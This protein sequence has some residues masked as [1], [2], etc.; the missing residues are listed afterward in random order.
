MPEVFLG[1]VLIALLFG[2]AFYGFIKFLQKLANPKTQ[3]ADE[4]LNLKLRENQ[5]ANDVGGASKILNYLRVRNR[6]DQP[7]YEKLR[8]VLE[9]EFEDYYELCERIGTGEKD[10]DTRVAEMKPG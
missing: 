1:L 10:R 3:Q 6:L 8:E 4:A 7:T 9:H 5:F 2:F